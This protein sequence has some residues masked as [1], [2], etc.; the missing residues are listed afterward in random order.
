MDQTPDVTPIG[1]RVRQV[2]TE[3]RMVLPGAQA[4]LGFGS[5]AVLMDAFKQLPGTLKLVHA[6]GLCFIALAIVLLMT[7]AAYHRIV[8]EGRESERFHRVASRLLLAAM[9]SLAPGLGAALWLVLE[10]AFESRAAGLVGAI[11][12]VAVF[13]SAWFGW[14]LFQR[15]RARTVPR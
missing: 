3:A 12:V 8:E 14:T 7:P 6:I 1:D 10:V 9:A 2:L 5:I 15:A 13:Y 11:G 4:L